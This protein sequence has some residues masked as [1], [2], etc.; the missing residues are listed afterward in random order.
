MPIYMD[1]HHVPGVK[2]KDVAE[3]HRLDLMHQDDFGCNCM[4]YWIDEARESIFCLIEAADR[5][6]V[7]AMHQKAHGLVPNKV[8]EV[9]NS[10]V[11]SFLGRIYDPDDA[12]EEDGMKVFAEPAWRLFLLTQTQDHTLLRHCLG[13]G[14]ADELLYG[15]NALV[16]R[17]ISQHEGSEAEHGGEGFVVSFKSANAAAE[18]ALAIRQEFPRE[19]VAE[20]GF[21][22]ALNGGEPIG[23]SNDLFGDAIRQGHYLGSLNNEGKI[24]LAGKLRDLVS[25]EFLQQKKDHFH[26][27]NMPDEELA[28]AIYA[29]LENNYRDADFDMAGYAQALGMSQPQLYRKTMA[30]TGK[31]GNALLKDF[32]LQKAK[33][34]LKTQ[35]YSVSQVTFDTGFSS[36]SYF[37]KCFKTE[38]G[39]L[40][41]E[42]LDLF[43]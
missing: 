39:L 22:I 38:F 32:R 33:E 4:T 1:I 27:L 29:Q 40:P 34:L 7:K 35:K 10:V 26:I 11:Q 31:S 14:K 25:K 20:L 30:L 36:P 17:N 13:A 8:I 41:G 3:A 21:R 42:Y 9:S 18:C 15:L 37:S 12:V 43:N 23:N 24:A 19:H 16:R 5:D 28:M 2:A 6:A